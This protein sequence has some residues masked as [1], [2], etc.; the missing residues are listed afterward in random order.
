MMAN[1]D[2]T[3]TLPALM[4]RWQPGLIWLQSL[5]M[6]A[7]RFALAVP[8]YR[9]GLTKWDGFLSLSPTAA[10]LFENQFKLHIF[11]AEYPFPYPELMAHLSGI[12]EIVFPVLLVIGLATRF[13]ALGTLVMTAVIFL[14][15]PANWPTEGLP[16][17]A[18]SLVIL[19]FGPGR[20]AVDYVI[21]RTFRR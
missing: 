7:L 20:I 2:R 5:A 21:A 3:A 12:G 19:A 17:A 14:T 6:L 10:F 11:G 15:Y 8:F 18:M 4:A 1:L 16:W 13:A 9:S